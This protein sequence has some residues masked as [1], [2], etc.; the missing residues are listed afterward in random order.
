MS[1]FDFNA[2]FGA[3]LIIVAVMGAGFLLGVWWAGRD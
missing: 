2:A 1:H 3:Y